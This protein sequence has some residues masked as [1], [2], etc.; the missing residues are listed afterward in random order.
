MLIN[1]IIELMINLICEIIILAPVEDSSSSP[2]T[3]CA[4]FFIELKNIFKNFIYF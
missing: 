4:H 2:I 3:I 1:N